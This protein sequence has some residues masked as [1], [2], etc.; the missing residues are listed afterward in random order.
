MLLADGTPRAVELTVLPD[1]EFA[2][3]PGAF[4]SLVV[5]ACVGSTLHLAFD[6]SALA[7][8]EHRSTLARLWDVAVGPALTTLA[9]RTREQAA[10]EQL[11]AFVRVEEQ[12]WRE[13]ARRLPGEIDN[14]EYGISRAEAQLREQVVRLNDLRRQ[15]RALRI[16]LPEAVRQAAGEQHEALRRLVPRLYRAVQFR[17]SAIVGVIGPIVLED[18]ESDVEVGSFEVTIALDS[19]Q[20]AIRNMTRVVNGIHH[21]HVRSPQDICL[22]NVR[23]GVTRL[24]AEREWAGLL[25]VIAQFLHSYA[26]NDAYQKL[27]AWDPD[28]SDDDEDDSHD[29]DSDDQSLECAICLE[30]VASDEVTTV[31]SEAVCLACYERDTVACGGCS[32]RILSRNIARESM[33]CRTCVPVAAVPAVQEVAS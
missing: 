21:P 20:L 28:R 10:R 12:V 23:P 7:A 31:Q 15:H 27:A 9:H 6:P 19:G 3:A 16:A 11:E 8:G 18:E 29:E 5:A 17:D 2:T 24:L 1:G 22:G 14:L 25:S 26:E 33:R 13:S 32:T 4:G 30:N